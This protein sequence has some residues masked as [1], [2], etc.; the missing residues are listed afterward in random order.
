MYPT[1]P[2]ASPSVFDGV[3]SLLD[4]SL[5]T[6]SDEA[7]GESRYGMLETIRDVGLERLEAS[8][9]AKETHRR[10][11]EWCLEFA[12]RAAAA[13]GGTD[14]DQ[15]LR[16]LDREQPN[17]RQ[18]LAFAEEH[19]DPALGHRFLAAIWPFWEAQGYFGEWGD[20]AG[21]LLTL[22]RADE[23]TARAR[24]LSAAAT[25]AFRRSEY[26]SAIELAEDA[27]ALARR[28]GSPVVTA[29]A[30]T[31][32]GHVAF[33]RGQNADAAARYQE[34]VDLCRAAGESDWLLGALTN[35]G[36]ALTVA[37]DVARAEDVLV[38]A[39]DGS[40]AQGRRFWEGI[41]LA[42]QGLLAK[43]RG[44]LDAAGARFVESLELLGDG[45]MLAVAGVLWDAA[46]V[47][48]ER[49]DL[50]QAAAYLQA[51]LERRWAWM[52]RR[53]LAECLAAAAELAVRVGR[54]EPALR[55]FGA[56]EALRRAI[57][58]LDS[59][60]LQPR[61][62][63][64]L[65]TA[66]RGLTESAG[67][68]AVAAGHALQLG[69]AVELATAVAEEI[70]GGPSAPSSASQ[71]HGLTAR[72]MEVLRFAAGGQSDKEIGVLLHISSRTVSRHLQSIYNKLGVNTRTAA[73]ARAR[74]L[75]LA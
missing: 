22:G 43:H 4:K 47:A 28:L 40:R 45:H 66:R 25:A 13:F 57:G 54:P 32:L 46:D 3:A 68:A 61:R 65:S 34:V 21:R 6:R 19:G 33:V 56:A 62:A 2:L 41:A 5:L 31:T 10:H 7:D 60:H 75:G 12:E 35:L 8:G 73:A 74:E 71:T 16:R 17:L 52:E 39:R 9:E 30:I 51:S 26:P 15:W 53:G 27:A 36:L 69:E 1:A 20:W 42:R 29:E 48:R 72:E 38:E 23:T 55:L 44:D 18:A 70:R 59:W 14:H 50:P 24:A 49:G 67:D 37:G 11:A 63:A 64:A 58:I